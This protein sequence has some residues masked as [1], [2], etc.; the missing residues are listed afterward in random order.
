MA[1][2]QRETKPGW[3]PTAEQAEVIDLLASGYSQLAISRVTNVPQPTIWSWQNELAFSDQFNA[4]VDQ[5]A[6]EFN[7]A[8]DAVHEQQVVMALQIMQEALSGEMQRERV[9][10]AVVTPLRFEAAVKLLQSTF[11][12]QIAGGHKK[13]GDTS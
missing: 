11:Y 3:K 1:K 12:K 8:R 6:A 9:G 4:L 2:S 5:R 7:A 13:F 10:D